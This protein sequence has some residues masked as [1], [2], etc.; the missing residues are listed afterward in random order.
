[1][2]T[3]SPADLR[4]FVRRNTHLQALPDVAGVR[5]HLADDVTTVWHR[6]GTTFATADPALPYWAFAWAGGLAICRYLLEHPHEVEDRRVLDMAT[7]SGMCAVVAL[8]AGAR[9]VHAVDI[10][11]FAAAAV[12]VNARA[13]AVRI[14]FSQRDPLDAAPPDCDLILAGDVC[15]EETMARRMLDWLR[16]AARRGIRVLIGDPGRTY[17][18]R[19]L[20]CLATYEVRTSREIEASDARPTAVY[21]IPIPA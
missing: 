19:D 15:Y 12:A 3:P 18:P 11:P 21:T 20:E 7:G 5:L 8:R 10:D 17:L 14:A 16:I 9:S 2:P 6:T 1:M 13:N 4:A